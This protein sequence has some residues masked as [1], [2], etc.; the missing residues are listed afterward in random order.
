MFHM[1][2]TEMWTQYKWRYP[3]K[4]DTLATLNEYTEVS[5]ESTKMMFCGN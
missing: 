1:I 5:F 2:N 4:S 3:G